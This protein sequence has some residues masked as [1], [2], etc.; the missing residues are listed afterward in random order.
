MSLSALYHI[1]ITPL[2]VAKVLRPMIISSFVS[3]TS[4]PVLNLTRTNYATKRCINVYTYT[5]KE[6]NV[7]YFDTAYL[8]DKAQRKKQKM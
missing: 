8:T 1:D 3:D 6:R 2:L 7:N 4:I 5:Y